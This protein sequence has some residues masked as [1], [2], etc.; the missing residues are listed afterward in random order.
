M[1]ERVP[2]EKTS[3][4]AQAGECLEPRGDDLDASVTR[5]IRKFVLECAGGYSTHTA[6]E[7]C[8]RDS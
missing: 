6:L 8:A 7:N 1:Q 2:V 3:V 5:G 4:R